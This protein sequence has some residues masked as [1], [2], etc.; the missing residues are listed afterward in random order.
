M[1]GR[2]IGGGMGGEVNWKQHWRSRPPLTLRAKLRH[3]KGIL[4]QCAYVMLKDWTG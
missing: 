3:Y 4:A 2:R 1:S